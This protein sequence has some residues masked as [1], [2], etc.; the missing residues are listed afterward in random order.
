MRHGMGIFQRNYAHQRVNRTDEQLL[1]ATKSSDME[2]FRLL[3]ERYQPMLFRS[4]SYRTRDAEL[5]HDLIQETFL[6]VWVHRTSLNPALPLFPYLLRIS[7]NLLKDHYKHEQVV[8][9][10]Q[11]E[12]LRFPQT[13]AVE[14]QEQQLF[15]AELE[16]K[17]NDVVE[18]RLGERCRTVFLLSR[19]E[20]KSNREIAQL[21][22]IS[23]K[24]VENQITHALKIVRKA[25]A[26]FL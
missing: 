1:S 4:L 9:R 10:H 16:E 23:Q 17:I 5:A 8:E 20:G 19:I 7:G 26:R 18:R 15:R 14:T 2:A 11:A 13:E 6:R 21:L 24:T 22:G 12:A 25:L 3:F